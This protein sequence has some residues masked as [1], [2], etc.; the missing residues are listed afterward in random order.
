MSVSDWL[1]ILFDH[2]QQIAAAPEVVSF[3]GHESP[4]RLG[5]LSAQPCLLRGSN[6]ALKS[7]RCQRRSKTG[8][9]LIVSTEVK[10][11]HPPGLVCAAVPRRDVARSLIVLAISI[12]A[13]SSQARTAPGSPRNRNP[14]ADRARSSPELRAPD[15]PSSRLGRASASHGR[16]S[17]RVPRV[18]RP[19]PSW[20]H[21]S[22]ICGS[23]CATAVPTST[24]EPGIAQPLDR[25]ARWYGLAA[26]GPVSSG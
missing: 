1:A 7:R 5:R 2:E 12:P 22:R 15:P 3:P 18:S 10:V 26:H 25:P 19:H 24:V 11:D 9:P 23:T 6:P 4:R 17:V 8:P 21:S 14:G 16:S 20:I 13:G